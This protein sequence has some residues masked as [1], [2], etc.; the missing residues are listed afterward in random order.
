[1]SGA[2]FEGARRTRFRVSGFRWAAQVCA[3]AET[4]AVGKGIRQDI[5]DRPSARSFNEFCRRKRR[6]QVFS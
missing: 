1:L 3:D 2:S 4:T 5:V 6:R